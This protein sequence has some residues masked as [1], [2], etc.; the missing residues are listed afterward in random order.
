M[1]DA[2]QQTTDARPLPATAAAPVSTVVS[3]G[4]WLAVSTEGFSEQQRGRPLEHLVKELVQNALDSVGASGRIALDVH[5]SGSGTI[6]ITCS[7]DGP[8]AADLGKLNV[9]FI[10]TKK[11]GVTQRGRMGRG[12][13]ELLSIAS[14]ATVRSRDQELRFTV[15]SGVRR[16]ALQHGL[17]WHA[18]FAVNMEVEHEEA[19]KPLVPYFRSLLL[20]EAVVLAVNGEAVPPRP[21]HRV[22]E[23]WLTTERFANGR[24]EK[25]VLATRVH[26]VPV[27]GDEPALIHEMGIPVAP[28]EWTEPFHCD[29]QQRVP[30]NPN[31]DAVM[32]GYPARL[33]RVCLA[34]VLPAM[35]KERALQPWV[36][37]AA[38]HLDWQTQQAVVRKAFGGM[39]VR[40]VP[41]VGR[42]DHDADAQE[43][44]HE[45]VHA[46]H[47]P[48]GFRQLVQT[49][50]HTS[51][52]VAKRERF[53]RAYAAT[54][55][56]L[57]RP[58][59]LALDLEAPPKG[60]EDA[61]RAIAEYGRDTV[62]TRLDF[63]AWF[64]EVAIERRYGVRRVV[65]VRVAQLREA[66][67]ATWSVKDE[68][69]LNL[70][71]PGNWLGPLLP[72]SFALL[73]HEIA[74]HEA[75]HHG[76]AFPKELEAYAG[77][78]ISVMLDRAEEARERFPSLMAQA[79]AG[80]S[81]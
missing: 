44:G 53:S 80:A 71:Y 34:A 76:R 59:V 74:H 50:V 31:R 4:E 41:A 14:S 28:V 16:V 21:V 7:D 75:F 58:D 39:V 22:V 51:A 49:H 57:T 3:E 27:A 70:A 79:Q 64:C 45:V 2:C 25:P 42:F 68:L 13:K 55:K 47:M 24:W 30:M 1:T 11:D 65:P 12:F 81:A 20:P 8:G 36:G 46:A 17:P 38:T 66:Y 67:D 32:V 19:G 62:L 78:A 29:V 40:A 18:G 60:L 26:L 5:P 33:Q 73:V 10:T 23:A 52:A 61:A 72:N 77:A 37:E 43:L 63:A 6:A 54:E 35:T 48:H 15:E 9:V 56:G 69:T